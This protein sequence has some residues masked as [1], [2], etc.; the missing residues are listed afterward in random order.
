MKR[1]SLLTT[2][3]STAPDVE[4]GCGLGV[5]AEMLDRRNF[6]F[7]RASRESMFVMRSGR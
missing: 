2:T 7:R 6:P 3:S 5:R 1:S 4:L